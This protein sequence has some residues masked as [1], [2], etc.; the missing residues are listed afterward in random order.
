VA[1]IYA[2]NDAAN[3]IWDSPAGQDLE[4]IATS[5]EPSIDNNDSEIL[6]LAGICSIR[7]FAGI[8]TVPWGTRTLDP[9]ESEQRYIAIAR[10]LRWIDASI[11]AGMAFTASADNNATTWNQILSDAQAFIFDL[12][13]RGAFPMNFRAAMIY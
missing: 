1:A 10:T 8:G 4:L 5:I 2:Q 13:S 3:E 12:Y 9:N 6:N 7:E 11:E